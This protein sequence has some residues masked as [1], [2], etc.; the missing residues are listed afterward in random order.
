MHRG[1]KGEGINV[2]R[3]RASLTRVRFEHHQSAPK[4]HPEEQQITQEDKREG[5]RR[6]HTRGMGRGRE[7]EDGLQGDRG[8]RVSLIPRIF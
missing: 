1:R 2:G 7:W 8:E 3:S 6:E 5:E 4:F